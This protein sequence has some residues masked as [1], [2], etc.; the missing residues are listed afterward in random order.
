MICVYYRNLYVYWELMF[1]HASLCFSLV[2]QKSDKFSKLTADFK[3]PLIL[4]LFSLVPLFILVRCYSF[5]TSTQPLPS[6]V[7][8]CPFLL[9]L[10]LIYT[11]DQFIYYLCGIAITVNEFK[12]QGRLY[13]LVEPLTPSTIGIAMQG[14]PPSPPPHSGWDRWWD[15]SKLSEQFG[16]GV[17][18]VILV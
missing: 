4:I 14:P 3:M 2:L 18:Q 16:G 11:F 12:G 6:H 17:R 1:V 8:V 7:I 5:M 10:V 9:T 13:I 15:F